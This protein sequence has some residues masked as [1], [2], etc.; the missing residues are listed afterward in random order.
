MASPFFSSAVRRTV[1]QSRTAQRKFLPH[2]KAFFIAEVIE[3]LLLQ[4]CAAPHAQHVHA[5]V[6]IHPYSIAIVFLPQIGEVRSDRSPVHAEKKNWLA[7]HNTKIRLRMAWR[8]LS[9]LPFN[10]SEADAKLSRIKRHF[11]FVEKLNLDA[12]KSL[13]AHTIRPPQLNRQLIP[14]EFGLFFFNVKRLIPKDPAAVHKSHAQ[15]LAAGSLC[16]QP[17]ASLPGLQF[18]LGHATGAQNLSAINYF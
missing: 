18:H 9:V 10:V 12:I 11:L 3:P 13:A 6:L 5:N 1:V 15:I 4:E 17:K 8:A 7:I 16:R 2:Q 14:R